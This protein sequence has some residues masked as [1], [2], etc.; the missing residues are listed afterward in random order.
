MGCFSLTVVSFV[1]LFI[2]L[3]VSLYFNNGWLFLFVIPFSVI[4][5]EVC[6]R[7]A[8]NEGMRFR[9]RQRRNHIESAQK[10]IRAGAISDAL[11]S[12]HKAKMYGDIPDNLKEFELANSRDRNA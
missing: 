8:N 1:S 9:D 2:S 7:Y 5:F 10:R 4:G 11:E 12:I 6:D 3:A